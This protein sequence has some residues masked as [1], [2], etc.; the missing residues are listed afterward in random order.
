[1]IFRA[2]AIK[3]SSPHKR[4]LPKYLGLLALAILFLQLYLPTLTEIALICL[5]DDNYSHGL[6]LPFLSI[7]I[8]CNARLKI[9]ALTSSRELEDK[10]TTIP[11]SGIFLLLA[12]LAVFIFGR[13]TQL[14]FLLWLS[15]FPTLIGTLYLILG[16]DVARLLAPAICINF[17]AKPLPDILAQRI[18]NSSQTLAARASA[19]VLDVSGVPVFLKGNVIAI[20]GM[21]LLVEEACS[22]MRSVLALITVAIVII[23]LKNARHITKLITLLLAVLL[24]VIFNIVRVAGTG[25]MAYFVS[26]S[27]AQGFLHSFSGAIA[28]LLGFAV[29]YVVV[30]KLDAKNANVASII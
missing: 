12:G 22:G 27:I 30:S 19:V 6:L 21:D 1:M 9:N 4:P 26:P 7:W 20:P 8:I 29:L 23:V 3:I 25:L 11:I 28:F 18:F 24:A 17:L 5:R 10:P 16:R 15:F 2:N 13:Q 14:L